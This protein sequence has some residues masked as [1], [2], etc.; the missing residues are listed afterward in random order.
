MSASMNSLL[1]VFRSHMYD[2][3]IDV[4]TEVELISYRGYSW[5]ALICWLLY[6]YFTI[7]RS[8]SV[9]LEE[10]LHIRTAT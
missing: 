10:W 6:S 2:F 3:L 1:N 5:S 9:S 4:F 8:E 7:S